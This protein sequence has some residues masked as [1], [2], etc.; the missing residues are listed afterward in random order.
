MIALGTAISC[1]TLR[2]QE[3]GASDRLAA[4]L[5]ASSAA[6]EA[7]VSILFALSFIAVR[8]VGCVLLTHVRPTGRLR[9]KQERAEQP[10]GPAGEEEAVVGLL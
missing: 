5:G 3:R 1:R 10:T 6:L 4:L 9:V 7:R 8:V 2:E